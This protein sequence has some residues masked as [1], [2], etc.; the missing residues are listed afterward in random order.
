MLQFFAARKS[1]LACWYRRLVSN[2]MSAAE[3]RQCGVRQLC[4]RRRQLL[5][6]SREIP[7]A[8]VE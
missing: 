3:R 2:A 8:L 5:M 7:L 1:I 4:A 6:D